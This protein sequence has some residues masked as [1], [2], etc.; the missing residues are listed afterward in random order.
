MQQ[1]IDIDLAF[2]EGER[3][4]SGDE[5][6]FQAMLGARYDWSKRW[7]VDAELRYLGFG[8]VAMDREAGR[9]SVSTDYDPVTFRLGIGYR[10]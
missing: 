3:S 9:G 8:E 2:P 5:F 4:Y 10:W 1:E 6:G 7:F